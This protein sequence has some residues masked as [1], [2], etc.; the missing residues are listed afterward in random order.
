MII[1]DSNELEEALDN[2][3]DE[4]TD[5][6]APTTDDNIVNNMMITSL[7][8]SATTSS[9]TPS[10]GRQFNYTTDSFYSFHN[11][12]SPLQEGFK[13]PSVDET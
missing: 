3:E 13:F 10:D 4:Q 6:A 5:A 8:S 11:S 1:N 2:A 12:P 9:T 7:R